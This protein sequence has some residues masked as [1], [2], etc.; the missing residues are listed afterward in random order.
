MLSIVKIAVLV[1]SLF[2]GDVLAKNGCRQC[3][4]W[5]T[6]TFKQ[7][8]DRTDIPTYVRLALSDKNC[9]T[10]GQI[11]VGRMTPINDSCRR[12]YG[13]DS[14]YSWKINIRPWRYCGNGGSAVGSWK[15]RCFNG[16]C[17]GLESLLLTC[18]Q[19]V[20]CSGTCTPSDCY[21]T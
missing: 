19:S 4:G 3:V 15:D 17:A 10:G 6:I 9:A 14:C 18:T 20:A 12:N 5:L 11:Q 1:L 7:F 21:S 13:I 2:S 8:M 16:Y